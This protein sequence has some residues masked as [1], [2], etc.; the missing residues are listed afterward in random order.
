MPRIARPVAPGVPHHVT[1][2]GN[3]REA[4]FFSDGDRAAYLACLADHCRKHAVE[5]LGYC[6]MTNHVHLVVVPTSA[7]GLE[8]VFRPLHTHYALSVYRQRGWSRHVWQGRYFLSPLDE[9]HFWATMRYVERNPVRAGLV[10]RAEDY[11]WSSARAHCGLQQDPVL[12]N[13]P[14][15]SET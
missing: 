7:N 9:A 1:Q 3:R 6:L 13:D 5:V 14:H 11:R 4:V 15:W 12:T 2:R 10:R 8:K